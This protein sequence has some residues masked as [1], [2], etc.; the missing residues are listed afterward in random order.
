M[1]TRKA[2]AISTDGKTAYMFPSKALRDFAVKRIDGIGS[3]SCDEY[4]K[5]K[6]KDEA[7]DEWGDWMHPDYNALDM[8]IMEYW[9]G[10]DW[11]NAEDEAYRLG[12][13]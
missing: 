10:G 13:L 8:S 5:I 6:R 7:R 12:L 9:G 2:Y 1:A 4:R 3:A 11:A